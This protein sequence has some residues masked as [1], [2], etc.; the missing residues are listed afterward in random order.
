MISLVRSYAYCIVLLIFMLIFA[1]NAIPIVYL[2]GIPLVYELHF[3]VLLIGFRNREKNGGWKSYHLRHLVS[4]CIRT[5]TAIFMM[6]YCAIFYFHGP[7]KMW[8]GALI[9]TI[10]VTGNFMAEIF[11]AQKIEVFFNIYVRVIKL[12][13]VFM[14][15]QLTLLAKKYDP[16]NSSEGISDISTYSPTMVWFILIFPP[17]VI[18]FYWSGLTA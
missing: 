13:R 14:Y 11:L 1:H 10:G 9:H 12:S 8:V 17:F 4:V 6:V 15:L 18:F 7:E 2:I 5:V 3:I 16:V